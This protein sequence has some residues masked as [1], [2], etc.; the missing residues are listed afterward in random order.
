VFRNFPSEIIK[1]AQN[2]NRLWK[3]V[4][5]RRSFGAARRDPLPDS[6]G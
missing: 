3:D 1:L 2:Y 6:P 5:A 4:A